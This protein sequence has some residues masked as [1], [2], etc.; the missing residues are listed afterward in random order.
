MLV[1]EVAACADAAFEVADIATMQVESSLV[2]RELAVVESA[3]LLL[4][5]E[6]ASVI[7][8]SYGIC[9]PGRRKEIYVHREGPDGAGSSTNLHY[10]Q[11]IPRK[12][13]G[14]RGHGRLLAGRWGRMWTL[15]VLR[16]FDRTR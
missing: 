3:R 15:A 14:Y 8:A 7:K 6:L 9:G 11:G 5:N 1:A 16:M 12:P 4:V 2:V 10:V 13:Q